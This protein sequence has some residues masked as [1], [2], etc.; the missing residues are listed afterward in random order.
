MKMTFDQVIQQL[1]DK[2]FTV[3]DMQI[4]AQTDYTPYHSVRIPVAIDNMVCQV[5]SIYS[6]KNDVYLHFKR[7]YVVNLAIDNRPSVTVFY[8]DICSS[9][10]ENFTEQELSK[11]ITTIQEAC[12]KMPQA[13]N[14]YIIQNS[15]N[16]LRSLTGSCNSQ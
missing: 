4:S 3:T 7:P 15:A 13:W 5:G 6:H 1:T 2:G 16:D 12:D 10:L 9:T 14:T 11:A 8:E